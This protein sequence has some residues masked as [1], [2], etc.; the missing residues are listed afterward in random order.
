MAVSSENKAIDNQLNSK[1]RDNRTKFDKKY[2]YISVIITVHDRREFI[3]EAIFSVINQTLNRA[4]Y[5]IIVVKNFEDEEIDKIIVEKGLINLTVRVDSLIGYDLS[6][7]IEKAQGDIIAF[8]DDDDLFMA[9]KLELVYKVFMENKDLAYFHNN[10]YFIDDNGNQAAFWMNSI[11]QDLTLND[12]NSF[13]EMWGLQRKGL[14]FNMSSISIKR[15]KIMEYLKQLKNINTNPDDFMFL[16][17]TLG[18]GSLII[19]SGEKLTKYRLHNSASINLNNNR[20]EFLNHKIKRLKDS[21]SEEKIILVSINKNKIYS[22][23]VKFALIIDRINLHLLDNKNDIKLNDLM[24]YSLMSFKIKSLKS[25]RD[26]LY[27][28]TMFILS[29]ISYVRVREFYRNRS[30]KYNQNIISGY[31]KT[32]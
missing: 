24:F 22:L 4:L 26:C 30:F 11:D 21:I 16:I 27:H 12:I 19:L 6:R 29:K 2:P 5:E 14:V 7:A 18:K 10:D 31:L 17:S 28:L 13:S 25:K 23:F 15:N 3:K 32:K 8:L 9:N 20:N 1:L